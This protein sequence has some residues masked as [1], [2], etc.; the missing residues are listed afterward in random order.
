MQIEFNGDKF[1]IKSSIGTSSMSNSG[2][3]E[4]RN[5]VLLLHYDTGVTNEFE[6][7]FK[8][9]E[10]SFLGNPQWKWEKT[11]TFDVEK[12]VIKEDN[13]ADLRFFK[14]FIA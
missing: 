1:N 6:Y 7:E 12:Q 2:T 14:Q 3:Y 13:Y 8:N 9:G 10:V 5:K 11:Y 4:I